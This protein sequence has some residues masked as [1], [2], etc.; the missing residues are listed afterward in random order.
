MLL[1]KSEDSLQSDRE[2]I[3][4]SIHRY[5]DV[6]FPPAQTMLQEFRLDFCPCFIFM[7]NGLLIR[8]SPMMVHGEDR[9]LVRYDLEKGPSAAVLRIKLLMAFRGYHAVTKENSSRLSEGPE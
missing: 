4:L 2:E 8:K 1:S 7:D 3:H 9:L 5:P 6:L